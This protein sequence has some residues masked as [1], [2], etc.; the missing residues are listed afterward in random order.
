MPTIQCGTV[1]F[2]NIQAVLFDKDGTL[3]D[4]Q[5][6]LSQLG[7]YRAN[8]IEAVVSGVREPLLLAFGLEGD[9]LNPA[10]LLAVGTRLEN[11]IAAAAYV[12]QAGWDW[13]ESLHLV[14][15]AFL[16]ADQS[17]LPKASHTPLF[18]G[19]LSLLQVLAEAGIK[20]GIVSSDSPSHVQ[21]FVECYQLESL[22]QVALGSDAALSKPNPQLVYRACQ[23]LGVHPSEI[24]VVGDSSADVEIARAAVTAGCVGVGWGGATPIMLRQCNAFIQEFSEIQL[25][26]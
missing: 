9:R 10:G 1:Q 22:V 12:A 3:A 5:A 2:Q 6:Y 26:S 8:F 18:T 7:H 11:E 14:R 19:A 23:D 25:I 15:S 4:S 24:L 20:T 13:M 17:M 16:K 21:E